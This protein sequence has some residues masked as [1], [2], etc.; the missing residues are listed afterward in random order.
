[1]RRQGNHS[2]NQKYYYR[3]QMVYTF[4]PSQGRANVLQ[5]LRQIA[6]KRN[7]MRTFSP[8][9]HGQGAQEVSSHIMEPRRKER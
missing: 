4:L 1:M 3:N 6:I 9:Y 5:H 7:A 2:N 8:L